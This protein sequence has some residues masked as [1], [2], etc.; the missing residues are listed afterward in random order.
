MPD[1]IRTGLVL[2]P[3]FFGGEEHATEAKAEGS[4]LEPLPQVVSLS[5]ASR[6]KFG[7]DL[8]GSCLVPGG[9]EGCTHSCPRLGMPLTRDPFGR[10]ADCG[11]SSSSKRSNFSCPRGVGS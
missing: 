1:P 7:A 3:A 10:D 11:G 2:P 9:I 6:G 4:T 8:R 5:L